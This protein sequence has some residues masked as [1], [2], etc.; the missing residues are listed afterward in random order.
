MA[1]IANYNT[2]NPT[3]FSAAQYNGRIDADITNKD[4]L[5]FAIYWVPLTRDNFNGNRAYDI[6]HHDQTNNAFSAIWNR[7]FSV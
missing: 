6:F 5:G 7:T 4:R 3:K 2:I 1:D